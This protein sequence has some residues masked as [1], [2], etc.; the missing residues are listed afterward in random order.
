[1]NIQEK[2]NLLIVDDHPTNL[3]VLGGILKSLEYNIVTASS[4][5]EAIEAV[6]L[7][8][9]AL[10]LL[11]VQ[12]PDLDG[13][14]TAEIIR[15]NPRSAATPIIFV[16]AAHPTDEF[17]FQG[18]AVGAVDYL[19][20]PVNSHILRSKVSIFVELFLKNQ[21]VKSQAVLLEKINQELQEKIEELS[22]VNEQYEKANNQLKIFNSSVSHDLR[23]PLTS[24]QTMSE[25]L[26]MKGVD[27][28]TEKEQKYLKSIKNA[29]K[30]MGDIIKD[31]GNLSL[32]ENQEIKKE[33]VDLSAIAH[34]ITNQ[35]QEN[36]PHRSA[37]FLIKEDMIIEGDGGLLQIVL[38]N[39]I[40]NAWKYSSKKAETIIEFNVI[41]EADKPVYFIKDNGAGFEMEKADRLF[42][43]FQRLHSA[44]EFEGTGV[45]LTTVHNIIQRHGGN[46]WAE[47]TLGE[48]TI[49]WFTIGIPMD[50][51]Q[52]TMNNS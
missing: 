20:K 14:Q 26:W 15:Q 23:N 10:I 38:E 27:K 8:D 37:K 44:Q 35:L 17:I 31:L 19:L 36:E 51:G 39:L 47:S 41:I 29:A 46:I 13:F 42:T 48:G 43:P 6:D 50:N 1:M 2:V 34:K 33:K 30:R 25:L 24:I 16:T 3:L 32:G 5:K 4:G 21:E 18:Y 7:R 11:D 40:G 45:G 22:K 9:F 49:F 28:L 52:W 12:M